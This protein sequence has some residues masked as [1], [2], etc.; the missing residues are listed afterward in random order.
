MRLLLCISLFLFTLSSFAQD[1][2]TFR[3]LLVEKAKEDKDRGRKPHFDFKVRG[4][5]Y[6]LDLNG[7]DRP[8]SFFASKRDGV[9]WLE[10][11]NNKGDKIFD[12]KF[13]T[14]GSWSRIYKVQM[15]KISDKAKL[16]I[17]YFYEGITRHVNFDGTARVYFLTWDNDNLRS[18][19]MFKGP[20][21]WDENRTFRNHYHQRKFELSMYDF[22]DDFTREVAVR[23]GTITRVYKYLGKGKWG[24]YGTRQKNR[25]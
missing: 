12:F 17:F 2:R 15:R 21:I 4:D 16:L 11:F 18:L 10:L 19:S 5:R 22:D 23:Y 24:T 3:E 25:N 9:D 6:Y 20:Y 14:V 1:E 7:D 8:E 13:D